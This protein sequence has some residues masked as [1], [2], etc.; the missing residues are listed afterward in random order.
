MKY[1]IRH[2]RNLLIALVID[3]LGVPIGVIRRRL[4]GTSWIGCKVHLTETHDEDAP[5][6]ITS[7]FRGSY[8]SFPEKY[9]G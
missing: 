9:R 8:S 2:K 5:H 6:K 4:R 3:F 1:K 7:P